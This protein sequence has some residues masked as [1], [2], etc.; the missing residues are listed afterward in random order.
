MR[1]GNAPA[2]ER[3]YDSKMHSE[4]LEEELYLSKEGNVNYMS[5]ALEDTVYAN[6]EDIGRIPKLNDTSN[7]IG[8]VAFTFNR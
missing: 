5:L 6:D 1:T 7:E 8:F 2:W 4:I 3:D